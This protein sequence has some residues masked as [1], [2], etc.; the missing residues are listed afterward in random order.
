[1]P[2]LFDLIMHIHIPYNRHILHKLNNVIVYRVKYLLKS[3]IF[4]FIRNVLIV[5]ILVDNSILI[6]FV[7]LEN[8]VDKIN[9]II[10]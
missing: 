10:I 5:Y 9:L 3:N 1:V 2:N 8:N 6:F 4:T 7:R